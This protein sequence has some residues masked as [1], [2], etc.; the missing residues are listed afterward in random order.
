M[1]PSSPAGADLESDGPKSS[2]GHV[3]V[4]E[5]EWVVARAVQQTLG[6]VG[7]ETV[8][9]VSSPEQVLPKILE[10]QPT[11]MLVDISLQHQ[12]DGIALMER[13]RHEA[14]IPFLYV[15]G[16]SDPETLERA[17]STRPRGFIVKPFTP[18]QLVAAVEMALVSKT[19]SSDQSREDELLRELQSARRVLGRIGQAL[20][21]L[22]IKQAPEPI[23]LDLGRFPIL[24]RL[25][26][27]EREVLS[28]LLAHRRPRSIARD[29]D[30]SPHTVRNHL[31]SIFNKVGVRSQEELLEMLT[32][33]A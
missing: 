4:V 33:N 15:S 28:L 7:F 27:R 24:G 25:T 10:R 18:E 6:G 14:P 30:I 17:R 32:H 21:E 16:L 19:T 9:W 2:R 11:L 22:G 13:L 26:E 23:G 5:D 31:K 29:L 1:P 8:D 3:L 20:G 12:E